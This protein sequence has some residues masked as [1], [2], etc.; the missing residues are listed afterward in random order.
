MLVVSCIVNIKN[1]H[2]RIE[3][4]EKKQ[5]SLRN[6]PISLHFIRFHFIHFHPFHNIN[7]RFRKAE[8]LKKGFSSL[9]RSALPPPCLQAPHRWPET[10]FYFQ[11]LCLFSLAVNLSVNWVWTWVYLS[12]KESG[13][14]WA[15]AGDLTWERSRLDFSPLWRGRWGWGCACLLATLE[16]SP[17]TPGSS[18]GSDRRSCEEKKPGRWCR[19]SLRGRRRR[20]WRPPWVRWP[21]PQ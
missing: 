18:I 8:K 4:S 11:S 14:A 2:Q 7:L 6:D 1:H 5:R 10:N 16:T 15:K 12:W 9:L 19:G 3:G 13:I 20:P 21:P 17:P